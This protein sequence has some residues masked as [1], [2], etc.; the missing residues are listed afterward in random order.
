[1]AF[2]SECRRRV[3]AV[4]MW[5]AA[6]HSGAW[7]SIR[8]RLRCLDQFRFFRLRILNSWGW[9]LPFLIGGLVVAPLALFLR[10]SVEELPVFS[11]ATEHHADAST[12]NAWVYGAKSLALTAG[13]VVSST[14][15]WSI[16]LASSRNSPGFLQRLLFGRIPRASPRW[17][18]RSQSPELFLTGLVGSPYF[19]RPRYCAFALSCFLASRRFAVGAGSTGC[20]IALSTLFQSLRSCVACHDVEL[21]QRH[22]KRSVFLSVSGSRTAIFEGLLISTWARSS[23]LRRSAAW[24]VG[25]SFSL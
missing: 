18:L 24:L 22:F 14:S 6:V 23:P 1:M 8:V 19:W 5:A 11:H 16:F 20:F 17:W 2:L 4:Y 10:R 9:W 7:H 21:F 15:I 13:W 25:R 12:Y 3:G